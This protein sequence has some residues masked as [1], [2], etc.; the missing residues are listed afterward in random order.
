MSTTA[1][2]PGRGY[3]KSFIV[4]V[5]A[6]IVVAPTACSRDPAEVACRV[7][8]ESLGTH[9]KG[10]RLNSAFDVELIGREASVVYFEYSIRYRDSR[11]AVLDDWGVFRDL[12]APGRRRVV[13]QDPTPS[14]PTAVLSVDVRGTHCSA[15]DPELGPPAA[16]SP[17]T[18]PK[19]R[20]AIPACQKQ[21]VNPK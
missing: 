14:R 4:V 19:H 1:F 18:R 11:G 7:T 21:H 12:L 20:H 15:V 6:S 10:E 3:R 13:R 5:L 2:V 17:R 9:L 8:V 16:A